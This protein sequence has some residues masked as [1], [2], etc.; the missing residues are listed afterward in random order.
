MPPITCHIL[1]TARGKPAQDVIVAI[2]RLGDVPQGPQDDVV[3]DEQAAPFG[4]AKTNSDGRIP[5]WTFRPDVDLA[6]LG[7]VGQEWET[8]RPGIYRARF[9]TGKYF[10]RLAQAEDSAASSSSSSGRTF[11]PFVDVLFT[12]T[13]PPDN[14]YHIPLLLSAHS[15]TTYRGS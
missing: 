4:I 1:D 9:Q 14:H 7:I 3:V 13:D 10:Q 15:Y 6:S 12:V 2:F 5:Q 8:L 11:F